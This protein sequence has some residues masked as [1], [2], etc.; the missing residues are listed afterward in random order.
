MVDESRSSRESIPQAEKKYKDRPVKQNDLANPPQLQPN[1]QSGDLFAVSKH[2]P[3]EWLDNY[4]AYSK[5]RSPRGYN[6]LHEMSGLFTLSGTVGGRVRVVHGRTHGTGLYFIGCAISSDYA[7]STTVNIARAVMD[8]AGLWWRFGPDMM[9]P[10]LMLSFM[11]DPKG[12]AD[13]NQ[14]AEKELSHPSSRRA[15]RR[16]H[17]GQLSWIYDEF[18]QK[19]SAMMKDFGPYAE[20]HG[21]LRKFNE[22]PDSFEY[23]TRTFGFERVTYP[24]LTLMGLTTPAELRKFGGIGGQLW[25]DGFFARFVMA[26]PSTSDTPQITPPEDD[27]PKIPYNVIEPLAT[28]NQRLGF[29]KSYH[30]PIPVLRMN[31]TLEVKQMFYQYELFLHEMGNNK[32]DLKPSYK[33]LAVEH[34][35]K[36]AALLA[37]VDGLENVEERHALRAI[38]IGERVRFGLDSL[39]DQLTTLTPTEKEYRQNQKED[40]ILRI[41]LK[42]ARPITFSEI[43][44]KTGSSAKYRMSNQDLSSILNVL[45]NNGVVQSMPKWPGS[46]VSLWE[47]VENAY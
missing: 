8:K 24:S 1:R 36:F 12:S 28:L 39:Y 19:L 27:I 16:Y 9:T 17:E 21:I 43:R 45:E 23:G 33:R 42:A 20:F 18:S 31:P 2:T 15:A 13:E 41:L 26:G 38:E 7:K 25:R 32:D 40:K 4:I 47:V 46:T 29:R 10:Q 30:D 3:H 14:K 11:A 5:R 35:P 37:A 6:T 22:R 44:R 34:C